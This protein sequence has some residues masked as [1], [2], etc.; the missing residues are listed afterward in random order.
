VKARTT[1]SRCKQA[2]QAALCVS[3]VPDSMVALQL[4]GGGDL[5]CGDKIIVFALMAG[6]VIV[7]NNF[8][9][10]KIF[11]W[12]FHLS[13]LKNQHLNH[14]ITVQISKNNATVP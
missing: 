7:K 11:R 5:Q 12:Y 10:G 8:I 13:N 1:Q 3:V 14:E 4:H 6:H 9:F 2:A